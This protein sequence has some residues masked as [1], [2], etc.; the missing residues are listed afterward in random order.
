MEN[1]YRYKKTIPKAFVSV[2]LTVFIIAASALA[3]L[4]FSGAPL[5]ANPFTRELPFTDL[6]ASAKIGGRRAMVMD[7]RRTVLVTDTDMRIKYR[8]HSGTVSG[9]DTPFEN[10]RNLALDGAGNLYVLDIA[11]VGGD[12]TERVFKYSSTGRYIGMVYVYRELD[13]ST[14]QGDGKIKDIACYDG[15]L[16]ILRLNR[17]ENGIEIITV[18]EDGGNT[19][20]YLS[21]P[22]A[23][24]GVTYRIKDATYNMSDKLLSVVMS[25]GQLQ[26]WQISA[27]S[28]KSE[29]PRMLKLHSPRAGYE[30]VTAVPS[31][32][33]N[34]LYTLTPR[35]K[36][37]V[38]NVYTDKVTEIAT[39][40]DSDSNLLKQA[41]LWWSPYGDIVSTYG[42]TLYNWRAEPVRHKE[43]DADTGT[44]SY[45]LE[46]YDNAI[47]SG[48]I[49]T[50]QVVCSLAAY[51]CAALLLLS[52][53]ALAVYFRSN[54]RVLRALLAC[55]ST[56]VIANAMC[57]TTMRGVFR[58]DDLLL[59]DWLQ[60][61][62]YMLGN[63]ITMEELSD[64]PFEEET[65]ISRRMRIILDEL[66]VGA[67]DPVQRVWKA[68]NNSMV[69]CLYD[70]EDEIP[71]GFP[72]MTA[73]KFGYYIEE[74]E[75]GV[76][77]DEGYMYTAIPVTDENV[78]TGYVETL[79]RRADIDGKR[80]AQVHTMTAVCCLVGVM[81]GL[82]VHGNNRTMA[83]VKV[84]MREE[85][86]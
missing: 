18:P 22:L 19:Q 54:R 78:Q 9:G 56:A 23:G 74:P 5:R 27:K 55:A 34:F 71:T 41:W 60:A 29:A 57:I 44:P 13:S 12:T 73:E 75:H 36:A 43:A 49:Y 6:S 17:D 62:G 63:S 16:W 14:R 7:S 79:V 1:K 51:I 26:I 65:K 59:Y 42:Q 52:V 39:P 76:R 69:R 32:G 84:K 8:L 11:R 37:A 70:S 86:K 64:K 33:G 66:P 31:G 45:Y 38:Y 21:L 28:E 46:R 4:Y 61:C 50:A 3:A 10:V 25:S 15:Q 83:T 47:V 67:L 53:C 82:L 30:I 48:D 68:D 77:S 24:A 80:T 35:G 81:A 58:S 2:T 72:Y 40:A 85:T 20:T